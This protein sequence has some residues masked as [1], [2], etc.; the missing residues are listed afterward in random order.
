MGRRHQEIPERAETAALV[1]AR[2]RVAV[3]EDLVKHLGLAALGRR[4]PLAD[5][6]VEL[7]EA[8]LDLA[9][10]REQRVRG[11]GHLQEP[12]AE[13]RGI[14]CS[15]R[16]QVCCALKLRNEVNLL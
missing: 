7:A 11:V 2:D 8:L 9:K 14:F 3:A 4:H 15:A 16:P 10:I 6:A 1:G 12:L 13:L 5:L